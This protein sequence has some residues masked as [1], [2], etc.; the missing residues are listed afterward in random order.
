LAITQRDK[1][2][3]YCCL[4]TKCTECCKKTIMLLSYHDI[5]RIKKLG[6]EDGF[7]VEEHRG[8]LRLKNKNG[9]CVFH[10]GT[11]CTIYEDRPEGCTLYPIV[12]DADEKAAM[13]DPEC[14][15]QN[16]FSISEEKEKQLFALVSAIMQ[17]RMLRLKNKR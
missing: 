15:H 10:D 1:E 11:E 17:E 6:Y 4:R 5:E 2:M 3:E 12:Y 7:F 13:L 14:P 8:W 16:C 9:R